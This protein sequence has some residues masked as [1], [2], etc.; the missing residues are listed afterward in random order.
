M[1]C[2]FQ[3]ISLDRNQT[4]SSQLESYFQFAVSY[5]LCHA[6]FSEKI[7]KYSHQTASFLS[8]K[9]QSVTVSRL[10][11]GSC[12]SVINEWWLIAV[13]A[14]FE[15]PTPSHNTDTCLCTCCPVLK[16]KSMHMYAD[17]IR[18]DY[19]AVLLALVIHER[20]VKL[21]S[22]LAVCLQVTWST[23]EGFYPPHSSLRNFAGGGLLKMVVENPV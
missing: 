12:L 13:L 20:K 19:F 18:R 6:P 16:V 7:N 11:H 21:Y 3:N 10:C 5:H 15:A 17:F 1:T 22:L 4:S 2:F 8:V 14:L 9:L 23:N